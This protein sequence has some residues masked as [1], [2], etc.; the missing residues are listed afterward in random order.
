MPVSIKEIIKPQIKS[1]VPTIF[2]ENQIYDCKI[3]ADKID[4]KIITSKTDSKKQYTIASI[5]VS[6]EGKPFEAAILTDAKE[7]AKTININDIVKIGVSVD[8]RWKNA[9]ISN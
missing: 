6:Y 2:V 8:G 7:Y 5:L 9:F 1:S 3:I 4:L